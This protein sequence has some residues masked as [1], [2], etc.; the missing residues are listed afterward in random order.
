MD[1]RKLERLPDAELRVMQA[2]WDSSHPAT[3]AEIERHLSGSP[4]AATTLLTLLSRLAARGF[5]AVRR[6]GRSSSYSP[7]VAREEYL[8]QQSRNFLQ[9]MF[10]GS[11]PAFAAALCDS[12]LS[13]EE[14][15][16][17]QRLLREDE[18]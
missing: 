17:L 14:L 16:E 13:K 15:K 18:L 2:L 7:A 11:I 5:V 12:G 6:E 4:M 3:R 1:K 8:A 9:R 10:G